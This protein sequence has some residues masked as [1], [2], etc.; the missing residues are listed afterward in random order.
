MDYCRILMA[1]DDPDDISIL[2]D[3]L[4]TLYAQSLISPVENG[5]AALDLL[6]AQYDAGYVPD[7]I[8][9]DLN[10]PRLNGSETLKAIK[11]DARLKEIPVI[12]YSTSVNPVEKAKC[13][14]MGAHA[15]MTK[16]ITYKESLDTARAFLEFCKLEQILDNKP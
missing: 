1:D 4:K 12:I 7:L 15:Y 14:N 2:E 6:N 9:L 13:L 8:V 3:A 10:M 16:P 11:N 5:Q